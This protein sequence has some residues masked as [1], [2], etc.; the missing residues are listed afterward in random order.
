MNHINND[1]DHILIRRS[2]N[3]LIV[4]GT[5]TILFSVWTVVKTLG[6]LILLKDESVAAIRKTVDE[7]GL[8]ISDQHIFYIVLAIMM[9]FMLLFLAVRAFIGLSAISEGRGFRRHKGYLVFA[10]I[11]IIM[12]ITVAV[13]NFFSAKSQE[14]L[15]ILSND[16]SLSAYIIEL[17]SIVM[18]VELVFS[19]IRIRKLRKRVSQGAAQKEQE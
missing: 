2:Q 8:K 1:I 3:T 19:A 17:T 15:W 9:I 11:M 10:V 5:G 14:P 12:S 18:L 16:T 13:I 4:V 6:T 7:N